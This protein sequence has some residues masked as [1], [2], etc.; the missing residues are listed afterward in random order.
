[1]SITL[2]LGTAFCAEAA[3]KGWRDL[4]SLDVGVDARDEDAP[5]RSGR[6][7]FFMIARHFRSLWRASDTSRHT[8]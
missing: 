4:R 5:I 7:G 1:M 3:E 6:G 2:W 8:H